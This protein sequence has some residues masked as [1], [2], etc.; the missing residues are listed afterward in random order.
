LPKTL[1]SGQTFRIQVRLALPTLFS[2]FKPLTLTRV[3]LACPKPLLHENT[4]KATWYFPANFSAVPQ[5]FA[6]LA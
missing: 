6:R 5:N 1:A 4:G 3:N 2:T